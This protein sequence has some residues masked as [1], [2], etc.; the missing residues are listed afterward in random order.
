V[1]M[2]AM[3]LVMGLLTY[4][5][6]QTFTNRDI[7]AADRALL[8]TQIEEA[9]AHQRELSAQV[10]EIERDVR[11]MSSRFL[12]DEEERE[13]L[14]EVQLLSGAIPVEGPGV[15]AVVDDAPD[16]SGSEG[17]VLDSDL[18]YL[19]N[20]LFLAGAEA[21]AINGHRVTTLTPIRSAG[22]AI[23]VDYVSLNAP[24]T[25]EAIGDPDRLASR[26][27]NTRAAAWWQYLRLNYGLTLDLTASD[28]DLQLPADS[29]MGLRYAEGG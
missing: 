1:T 23:T 20:G 8:L 3:T 24:Y 21:V 9:R 5:L 17:Y 28:E 19:V 10:A 4:A 11:A 16:A 26:F 22:A 7:E 25:V 12:P 29:G 14:A 13:A 6:T 2:V 15:V 18:S 27:A